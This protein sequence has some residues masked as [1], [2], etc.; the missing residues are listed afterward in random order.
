M[1][2]TSSMLDP[3]RRALAT[4]AVALVAPAHGAEPAAAPAEPL[5]TSWTC[6][7]NGDSR[8]LCRVAAAPAL[9]A[10]PLTTAY[11]GR[12]TLPEAVRTIHE[13]PALLRGRTI[14]IPLHSP[15]ED[16]DNAAELACAVMCGIRTA[17]R[18]DFFRD[19]AELALRHEEDPAL[20]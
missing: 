11:P 6:W 10:A 13:R 17:C 9:D 4:L 15:P 5:E 7:Y 18:V 19:V 3:A 1:D 12:D 20:E 14:T 8:V 16:M 2:T